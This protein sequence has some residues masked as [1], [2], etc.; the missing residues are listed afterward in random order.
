MIVLNENLR[1]SKEFC[2]RNYKILDKKVQR[3]IK[4]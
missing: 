3:F 4:N 1:N 2:I